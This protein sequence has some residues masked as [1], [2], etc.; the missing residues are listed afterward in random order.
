LIPSVV[1]VIYMLTQLERDEVFESALVGRGVVAGWERS[2]AEFCGVKDAFGTASG[3]M[4]LYLALKAVG[5]KTGDEVIVP[6]LDW[7]AATAAALHLGAIPVFADTEPNLPTVSPLSV[8]ERITE[9]TKAIVATHLFGYP[10]NMPALRSLADRHGIALIED[11]AQALGATC[12]GKKVGA[13]GDAACFSFGVGKALCCGEGG[14]IVTDRDDIAERILA[15]AAHPLRQE[16]EGIEVNPFALRAPLSPIAILHLLREWEQLE[17]RLAERCNAFDRINAVLAETKV[18]L[19]LPPRDGCQQSGYRFVALA[20]SKKVKRSAMTA[21]LAAGLPVS[22]VFGAKL[23]PDELA[24]A[25]RKGLLYWH[26]F[27]DRLLTPVASFPCP[28]AKA[29]WGRALVLDWRIGLDDEALNRFRRTLDELVTM[30]F[31]TNL[32]T[33]P[34]SL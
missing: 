17:E 26:P 14:M 7:Y 5:V 11:C 19:P 8:E 31:K 23:L 15:L 21:L 4:A 6:A 12:H 33:R 25:L 27:P 29:F 10:C 30:I 18:L 1:E 3:T 32:P 28:N 22:D 24:N 13:W 9:R 34:P 2:F 16:W 20:P